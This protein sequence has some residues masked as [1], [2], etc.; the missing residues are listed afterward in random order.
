MKSA[1]F[2][3]AGVALAA[4]FV[5]QAVRAETLNLGIISTEIR[6]RSSSAGNR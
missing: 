5:T 4:C 6:P 3:L 2:L 1:R